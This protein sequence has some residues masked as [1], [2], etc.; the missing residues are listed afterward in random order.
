RSV[1]LIPLSLSTFATSSGHDAPLSPVSAGATERVMNSSSG[2]AISSNIFPTRSRLEVAIALALPQVERDLL[3]AALV[4]G[5]CGADDLRPGRCD[6]VEGEGIL[7]PVVLL[8]NREE[9][10]GELLDEFRVDGA[11]DALLRAREQLARHG[12]AVAVE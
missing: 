12:D 7:G 5:P 8:G 3:A 6:G 4:D 1:T 10:E 9:K 2:G 11:V